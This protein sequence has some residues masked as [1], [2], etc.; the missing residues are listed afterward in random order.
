MDI[1]GTAAMGMGIGCS[2]VMFIEASSWASSSASR[3][4]L[5]CCSSEGRG[6]LGQETTGENEARSRE[7]DAVEL[8]RVNSN[9]RVLG[10]YQPGEGRSMKGVRWASGGESDAPGQL[11]CVEAEVGSRHESTQTFEAHAQQDGGT[12][13]IEPRERGHL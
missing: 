3:L 5:A 6:A 4:S 11:G 7:S 8:N 12:E 1:I 9:R 2:R 10:C 13:A